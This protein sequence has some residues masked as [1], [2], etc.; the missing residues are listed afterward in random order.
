MKKTSRTAFNARALPDKQRGYAQSSL[1]ALLL[2]LAALVLPVASGTAYDSGSSGNFPIGSVLGL[3]ATWIIVKAAKRT[4]GEGIIS[5]SGQGGV[6]ASSDDMVL[7]QLSKK[8]RRYQR[9]GTLC[10]N[11]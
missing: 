9:T 3:L 4:P 8:R 1:G 5:Y 6:W 2:P 11:F 7:E 10:G